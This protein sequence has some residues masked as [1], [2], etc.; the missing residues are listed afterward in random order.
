MT[1]HWHAVPHGDHRNTPCAIRASA[2]SPPQS[3]TSTASSTPSPT[4]PQSRPASV[5]HRQGPNTGDFHLETGIAGPDGQR[6]IGAPC[7]RG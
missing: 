4:S 7:A 3:R 6:P 5:A 1:C 2:G